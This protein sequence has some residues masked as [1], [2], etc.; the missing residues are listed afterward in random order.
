VRIAI[1]AAMHGLLEAVPNFSEGRDGAVLDALTEALAGAGARVLDVHA[2]A[3]H[4][5]SV[6]TVAADPDSLFGGYPA[7]MSVEGGYVKMTEAPGAGIEA[8]PAL[9]AVFANLLR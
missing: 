8:H 1:V 2:D 7:G 3:D 9:S 6:F 5:R 4:N